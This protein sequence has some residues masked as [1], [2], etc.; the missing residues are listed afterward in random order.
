MRGGKEMHFFSI[1]AAS[2]K[3]I[4]VIKFH[5]DKYG[6]E[7]LIDVVRRQ[8]EKT[9][10]RCMP[11][12]RQRRNRAKVGL[13]TGRQRQTRTESRVPTR[14]QGQTDA[15]TWLPTRRQGMK[16]ARTDV[17]TRRQGTFQEKIGVPTERQARM[18][19]DGFADGAASEN[20]LTDA[21][22]EG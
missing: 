16:K 7:L 4:P 11:T 21:D 5:K 2:M 13:P 9:E 20:E 6:D 8:T 12:G 17:P 15:G 14:R 3:Q 10:E 19:S 1:R 22:A 18:N